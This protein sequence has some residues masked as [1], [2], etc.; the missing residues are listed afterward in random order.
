MRLGD[1]RADADVDVGFLA[2]D[3]APLGQHAL[4]QVDDRLHVLQRLFRMADHEVEFDSAPATRIDGASSFNH[5]F[6]GYVLVDD[7]AH[8]LGSGF[9]REGE[10]AA[11]R[12]AKSVQQVG[13]GRFDSQAWQAQAQP[14]IVILLVNG[15]HQFV[16]VHIIR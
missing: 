11:A 1:K 7:V 12:V 9:R 14:R 15:F 2:Q 5:L 6:V 4:A 3:F 13:A 10:S 8:F 16:H